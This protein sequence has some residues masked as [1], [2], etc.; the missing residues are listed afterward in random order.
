[1]NNFQQQ[2]E[3]LYGGVD[4][5]YIQSNVPSSNTSNLPSSTTDLLLPIL[6]IILVTGVVVFVLYLNSKEEKEKA[7]NF[8]AKN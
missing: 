3:A 1:M 2:F 5:A 8:V 4:I 6:G 7:K